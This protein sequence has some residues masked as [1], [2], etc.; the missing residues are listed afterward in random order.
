M[1]TPHSRLFGAFAR[2][3]RLYHA[4]RSEDGR[5]DKEAVELRSNGESL[6]KLPA[7]VHERKQEQPNM[8]ILSEKGQAVFSEFA[9][10]IEFLLADIPE[11]C[12]KPAVKMGVR[13]RD[14][15]MTIRRVVSETG[16]SLRV[17][18]YGEQQH[19]G[20]TGA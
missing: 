15:K 16:S 2:F 14:E 5:I 1:P 11:D 20:V 18:A 13:Y 4:E 8:R 7:V 9:R 3:G 19:T 12:P 10:E 17:E 6:G